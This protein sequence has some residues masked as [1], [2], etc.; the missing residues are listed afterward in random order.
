MSFRRNHARPGRRLGFGIACL[1]VLF[2]P[3]PE[4]RAQDGP[5]QG[6]PEEAPPLPIEG[7][8]VRTAE[9]PAIDG[10]L[11]DAVWNGAPVMTDFIQREPFDGQPAS[12][13][14]EVRMVFDDEAIYV[15]VWAFDEDPAAIIPG[16]RI[17]DAEVSE[18][19][20]VLLAFD[21]YHAF[22]T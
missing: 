19:D 21:T 1:V 15:G 13:R 2:V 12:E 5:G 18:T 4:L 10:V 8:A 9:A 7:L 6:E 17:R 3:T 22:Q 14:T 16:D 11:N 20:H